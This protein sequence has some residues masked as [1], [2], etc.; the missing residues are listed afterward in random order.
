MKRST[1]VALG[2]ILVCVGASIGL[3]ANTDLLSKWYNLLAIV[4]AISGAI[5]LFFAAR[6]AS[7]T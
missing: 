4:V 1:N 5:I 2:A 3:L 6:R 7:Q